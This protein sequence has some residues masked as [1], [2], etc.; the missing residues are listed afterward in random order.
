MKTRVFVIVA[1]FLPRFWPGR[2]QHASPRTDVFPDSGFSCGIFRE[3]DADSQYLD[4]DGCT[5][6]GFC[7]RS[8]REEGPDLLCDLPGSF[9]REDF[10]F[11]N[12][13]GATPEEVEVNQSLQVA[14][15]DESG[16]RSPDG[17]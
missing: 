14:A 15:V 2:D 7:F 9:V 10:C 6:D 13:A 8:V 11:T 12:I 3:V 4:L 17:R 5:G 1:S 16:G